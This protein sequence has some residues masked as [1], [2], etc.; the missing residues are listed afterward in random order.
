LAAET[1]SNRNSGKS[2]H[3]YSHPKFQ[4]AY[5]SYRALLGKIQNVWGRYSLP[6]VLPE[7]W[8]FQGRRLPDWATL[9]LPSVFNAWSVENVDTLGKRVGQLCFP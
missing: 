6:V 9:E 3:P 5:L 8:N 7:H 1:I 2:A 4:K